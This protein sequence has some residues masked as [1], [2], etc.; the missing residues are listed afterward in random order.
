MPEL[1]E[2]E[3]TVRGLAGVL[4]GARLARVE[5]RRADLR[6]PF[7]ADLVQVMTGAVVTGLGRRAKYGLIHLDRGQTMIFHLGMSGRWRIEPE[8]LGPHDHLVIETDSGERLA[9]CDPRRF[10]SVDLVETAR[11]GSWPAFATLGPEPLGDG[12][13]PSKL[14]SALSGRKA[15]IKLMLLDQRIVAGLGNIYVCEALF[16]AGIDPRKAAGAVSG[17]ALARLVPQIK[18]VIAEAI[19][20]GGSSLRDYARPDGE[21]GYF[22]KRF[23]VYD[24]E[25]QPCSRCGAPVKRFAQGG[26]STWYCPKC[27]K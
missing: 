7:P 6:R 17:Q 11:I 15:A 10:G 16:R 12:L 2:V 22:S 25:G 1:P 18:A 3:T 14:K 26:R 23:D 9:L 20:A 4:D 19:E 24:R 8:S 21:L 5:T 13:S 27:Q